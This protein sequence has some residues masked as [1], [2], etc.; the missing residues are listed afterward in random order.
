MNPKD[1]TVIK[2]LLVTQDES[3]KIPLYF[4]SYQ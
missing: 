3:Q 2:Q 4:L 1:M